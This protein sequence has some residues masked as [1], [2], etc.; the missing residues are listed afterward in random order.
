MRILVIEHDPDV[1]ALFEA[2]FELNGFAVEVTNEGIEGV[3]LA[4]IYDFDVILLDTHTADLPGL[5]ALRQMRTAKVKT[6]VMMLSVFSAPDDKVKAF[7]LGADDYVTKPF[8]RD[9]L[10]ARIGALVRRS[11]GL[12][13]S[14]IEIGDIALNMTN[15]TVT[16]RGQPVHLTGKQ[17][18]M[19]ELLVLR[20]GMTVTKEMMLSHLYGG[21]DEPDVKIVD[22]FICKLRE[23]L[24]RVTGPKRRRTWAKDSPIQ[25]IWGRGYMLRDTEPATLSGAA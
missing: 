22:V 19:L 9:E 2:L 8:H 12:S 14:I 24:A 18:Q 10:I 13:H 20:K 21:L 16:V 15:R 25:T 6:P 23:K 11:R 7:A 4:K 5:D 3:D 17:Y 1:T